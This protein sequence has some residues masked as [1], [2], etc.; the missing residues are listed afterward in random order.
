MGVKL[1][2]AG[3]FYL[4]N[5]GQPAVG[6]KIETFTAGTSPI[7]AN[8]KATFVDHA[9]SAEN[10]NPIVL[11]EWGQADIWWSGTY[12][13]T[14]SDANNTL[15]DTIDNY[16]AG[17]EISVSGSYNLLLNGSFETDD[18][19]DSLPD[20]WT[21]TE[22]DATST[23]VLDTTDPN[24]G[25]TCLKFVSTG[26]GGGIAES[27]LFEVSGS[28]SLFVGFN[29]KSSVVD[30][31]NLVE[32]KYYDKDQLLLG[33][34]S[35]WDESAA[36]PTTWTDKTFIEV[37]HASARYAKVL[38]YGCHSSDATSGETRYDNARVVFVTG[39][40]MLQNSDSISITG[41]IIT[42]LTELEADNIISLPATTS[43][44]A[45]AYTA[46]VGETAYVTGRTYVVT[47]HTD[48]TGGA[49]LALDGLPPLTI[50]NR[51]GTALAQGQLKTN[52]EARLKYDGTDL[53]L[54]NE[55]IVTTDNM[56]AATIPTSVLVADN[57]LG[58][59]H[60]GASAIGQGELKVTN[61]TVSTLGSANLTQ[62]GGAYGFYMRHYDNAL[63][64]GGH[65]VQIAASALNTSYLNSVYVNNLAGVNTTYINQYYFQASPPYNLGDGDIP[66]FIFAVVNSLGVIEMLYVAPE[67]PWHYN[68]K[69]HIV[70]T[71]KDPVS[72]RSWRK[73]NA[74]EYNAYHAPVDVK[75]MLQTRGGITAIENMLADRNQYEIE[76]TQDIKNRDM[77]DIPHPFTLNDLTGKTVIML[78][79]VSPMTERL[80][81]LHNAGEGIAEIIH[82]NYITFDNSPIARVA[83]DGVMPVNIKWKN[84][85]GL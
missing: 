36:N 51:F 27:T 48:N 47:I 3:R 67:A 63:G 71:R 17:E 58:Q 20:N 61:G 59:N 29:V 6:W 25:T 14:I 53:I 76:L 83:P 75:S 10:T 55:A 35:I 46:T 64:G 82:D 11:D 54:Q 37:T 52:M 22:Y 26:L 32:I 43:G 44:S 69:T 60:I 78:D 41:G 68:G 77:I 72:G 24:H 56:T 70:A 45:T 19:G 73:C 42:G 34:T 57:G 85:A 33:T 62:A 74:M 16:G 30:V 9:R 23:V 79:P 80:L 28:Q 38:F 15:I 66:L 8:H 31:R 50:K 12:K 49:T 1:R 7:A 5:K 13:I 4:A 84:K 40:M 81:D 39:T 21:I 18:D 2:A 65:A